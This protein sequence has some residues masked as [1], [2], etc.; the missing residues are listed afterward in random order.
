MKNLFILLVIAVF[1]VSC[2]ED[3]SDLIPGQD[4]IP[5]EILAEIKANGQPIFEGLNPPD[6]SGEFLVSPY[7][8]V[9][10]NFDDIWNPGHVFN[11]QYIEFINLDQNT[12]KLEVKIIS[13]T[14]G[15]T[16]EG[17]GSFISG[18]GN[19]FTVFVRVDRTDEDGHTSLTTEVYSGTL[20]DNGILNMYGS[21]FMVDDNG[22][23][24]NDLLENGNGRLFYDSD[25]FSEKVR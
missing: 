7:I 10:S 8:L 14:G 25:G 23:P 19:D 20:T 1:F 5:E 16:G 6:I 13:G 4:F 11:D 21:L 24:N 3:H 22:D 9:S 15:S 17:F 2:H 12:L 18:E